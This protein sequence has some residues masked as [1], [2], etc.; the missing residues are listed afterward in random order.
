[1]LEVFRLSV[2][3]WHFA[4]TSEINLLVQHIEK[5]THARWVHR[6]QPVSM[7]I[8]DDGIQ[9]MSAILQ[10]VPA[11]GHEAAEFFRGIKAA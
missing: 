10:N 7:R 8:C 2:A 5:E 3:G 6:R 9:D 11:R 4:I 1:M